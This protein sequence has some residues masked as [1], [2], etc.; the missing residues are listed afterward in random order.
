MPNTI[1]QAVTQAISVDELA[2]I[3]L[4]VLSTGGTLRDIGDSEW[5]HLPDLGPGFTEEA[6]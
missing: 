4:R 1:Q 6:A 5:E 3:S 2:R